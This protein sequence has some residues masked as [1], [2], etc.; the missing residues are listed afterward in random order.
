MSRRL[1]AWSLV[2]CSFIMSARAAD[3]PP[4]ADADEA[5]RATRWSELQQAIFG[6]RVIHDG[7]A[8][9]NIE[10]PAR[11]PRSG[12]LSHHRQQS[13]PARGTFLLR[14]AGRSALAQVAGAGQ[15]L[16]LYSRGRR[17]Q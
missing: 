3:G 10:A 11:A 2:F 4:A 7:S 16:H 1:A 17:D 14:T 6:A 13:R 5:G 9:L 12:T 8:W 15:R